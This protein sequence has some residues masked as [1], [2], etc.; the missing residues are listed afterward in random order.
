MPEDMH[1]S[2]SQV[3]VFRAWE[4]DEEADMGWLLKS[5]ASKEQTED[6]LRGEAFHA[7]L[8]TIGD[9]DVETI[10]SKGF[11]FKFD[12]DFEIPLSPHREVRGSKNYGGIKIRGRVDGANGTHIRDDKAATWFD[13]ERYF[14]KY[15]WRYYLDIFNADRFTWCVWQMEETDEPRVYMVRDLHV[16]EQFRYPEL[17]ADCRDMA[18]RLKSF[19]EQH[20]NKPPA[21]D[22]T[23][24]ETLTRSVAA[25]RARKAEAELLVTAED[26]G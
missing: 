8:E 2:V 19:A 26:I 14:R 9:G 20:L 23:M 1:F 13:A 21:K 4:D 3:D 10:H 11:T 17:E 16:I 22:E 25:A 12:G 24:L 15:A 7:A 5:L 6:M 18:L